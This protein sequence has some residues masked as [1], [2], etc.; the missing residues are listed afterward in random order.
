V[1]AS[2]AVLVIDMQI[3][4]VSIGHQGHEVLLRIADLLDR[5]RRA[6]VPIL[7]V[8]HH[9]STYAP[10]RAGV[11]TWHIHPAVAPAEGEIVSD[12]H[13]T[14]DALLP[15]EQIIEYHNSIL[16]A[17]AHPDR[18]LIVKPSNDILF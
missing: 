4:L 13:T 1:S 15:A 11:P 7:H 12:A 2:A 14:K 18:R 6:T 9:H 10:L 16:P 8:Q 5:A 3:G 17:V